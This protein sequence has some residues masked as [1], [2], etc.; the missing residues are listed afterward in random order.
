M[1][2]YRIG[3]VGAP[4]VLARELT[5]ALDARKLPLLPSRLLQAPAATVAATDLGVVEFGD[6]A[7]LLEPFT[8]AQWSDLDALF[9]AGSPAEAR[10]AWSLV[11][12]SGL[13]VIDLTGALAG[14]AE[15]AL[16][17]LETAPI[18]RAGKQRLIVVAHPAA[19]ALALLL[20]QLSLAGRLEAAATVFEPASQRGLA[21]IQELEQ[22]MRRMFAMQAPPQEIFGAQVACNLRAQLGAGIQPGLDDIRRQMIAQV[23]AL[24]PGVLVPA[25]TVLQAPI[26]HASVI[27][28]YGRFAHNPDDVVLQR[29]LTSPWLDRTTTPDVF[30]AAGRDE[31][32]LGP[33]QHDPAGGF[34]LFAMLDNLRRAA[35][36]AADAAAA[37]LRVRA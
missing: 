17:G 19:Q 1:S 25:L 34:W 28:L 2:S 13:L 4:G 16:A 14:E 20:N 37:A 33:V 6:E 12:D 22:Q 32:L 24:A 23:A 7:A 30:A 29:L 15:V 18:Q 35:Y 21:G 9:L 11:V 10:A 8:P 31:I 3:I 26:F 5:D 27:S 36:S